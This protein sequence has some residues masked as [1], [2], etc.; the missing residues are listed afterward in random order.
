MIEDIA[1]A[2]EGALD[3]RRP[4]AV[5]A[6]RARGALTARER[7]TLLTDAGSFVEY[8]MLAGR[9]SAAD[10][11]SPA[12]GLV[13]GS[14][15]VHGLPV[16]VAASDRSVLNGTQSDRNQRK[17]ARLL[18]MAVAERWPVVLLL[19]GD[20]ARPGDPLPPRRLWWRRVGATDCS[21]VLRSSTD[22]SRPLPVCWAVCW[23]ESLPRP[24][25][26]ILWWRPPLPNWVP[27][28]TV[29]PMYSR[30]STTPG[31]AT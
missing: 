25:Y 24:C 22:A 4:D 10:D 5:A 2:A 19:D 30:R 29:Q 26:A 9:T 23:M 20:G 6:A 18:H 14:A 31:A 13:C 28:L 3:H 21:M 12:D 8:G 15:T 17:F 7:V 27:R 1:R 16:V 11:N